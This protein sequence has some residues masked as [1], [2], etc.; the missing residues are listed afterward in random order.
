MAYYT[1]FKGGITKPIK[2]KPALKDPLLNIFSLNSKNIG[3]A[4]NSLVET[5]K[6]KFK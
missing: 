6:D 1:S 3:N 5:L 4:N 2:L